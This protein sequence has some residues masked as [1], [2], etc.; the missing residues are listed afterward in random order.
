MKMA[1]KICQFYLKAFHIKIH[2]YI[3]CKTKL[4]VPI[5]KIQA[6]FKKDSKLN[7]RT[8]IQISDVLH[9]F[10]VDIIALLPIYVNVTKNRS[11]DCAHKTVKERGNYVNK[12]SLYTAHVI[13]KFEAP[14]IATFISITKQFLKNNKVS[15]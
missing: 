10:S 4:Q 13:P 11:K 2:I 7:A 8:P 6:R 9:Q 12:G 1:T 5:I 14:N 15:N 3:S